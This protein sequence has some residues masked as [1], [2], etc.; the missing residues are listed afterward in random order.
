MDG[1][2]SIGLDERLEAAL[3]Y[4]L[5]F[6]TGILFYL[7]EDNEFVR[8][9][10]VQSII[11]FGG[12][13][14]VSMGMGLISTFLTVIPGIGPLIAAVFATVSFLLM[15]ISFLL[16]LYLMYRAYSGDRY[17]VPWAGR[18]AERYV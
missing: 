9:H 14:I 10:A 12:L 3:T 2:T 16:W 1:R 18:Y 7:L 13:F 11:V 17:H 4:L 8:F 15:P 6:L 5:G